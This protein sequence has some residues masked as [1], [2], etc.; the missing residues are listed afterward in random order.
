MEI[1]IFSIST[2]TGCLN[3]ILNEPIDKLSP[4]GKVLGLH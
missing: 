1:T 4:M 2:L 3:V